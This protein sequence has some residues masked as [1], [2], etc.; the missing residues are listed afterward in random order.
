MTL[1]RLLRN[2]CE[3]EV[4]IPASGFALR[5]NADAESGYA[6]SQIFPF[7]HIRVA[8]IA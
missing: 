7:L 8:V 2:L 4:G 6:A 5:T 3:S 1:E